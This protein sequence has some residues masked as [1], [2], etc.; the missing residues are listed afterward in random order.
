MA[1]MAMTHRDAETAN[2][3]FET[4][5]VRE[6]GPRFLLVPVGL[7][8][9]HPERPMTTPKIHFENNS[10]GY[11]GKHMQAPSIAAGARRSGSSGSRPRGPRGNGGAVAGAV[12]AVHTAQKR[13]LAPH[14]AA[15]FNPG[16]GQRA[17]RQTVAPAQFTAGTTDGAPK[18]ELKECKKL[19]KDLLAHKAAWPFSRPVD[20]TKFPDYYQAITQPMDL[21]TA[22]VCA[23]TTTFS[24]HTRA[25][26]T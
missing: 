5:H 2:L 1:A 20:I 23:R 9:G 11:L 17:K 18:L 26:L 25:P 14:A 19:M 10:G 4:T 13:G 15:S 21:G 12:S 8:H 16:G 22:K 6:A 24:E 7:V 3:S